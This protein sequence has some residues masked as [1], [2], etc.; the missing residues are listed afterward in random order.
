MVR[1]RG[2]DAVLAG[3]D[4]ELQVRIGIEEHPLL[5]P[6]RLQVC[7]DAAQTVSKGPPTEGGAVA[8]GEDDVGFPNL[9]GRS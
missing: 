3:L 8:I 2:E 9:T 6:N 5:Q 1:Q 4:G 7:E